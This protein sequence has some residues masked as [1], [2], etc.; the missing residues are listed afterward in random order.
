MDDTPD[1]TG[2]HVTMHFT[3]VDEFV[4]FCTLIRSA[5]ELIKQS[6]DALGATTES[7][8]AA[9]DSASNQ[10]PPHP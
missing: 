6:T 1:P 2:V 3:T 10:P 5:T 7:L 9:V 8:R 4:Q